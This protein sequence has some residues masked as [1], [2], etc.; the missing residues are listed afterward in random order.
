MNGSDTHP[1]D[2]IVSLARAMDFAAHK[3][4]TQRRK[5]IKAESYVIHLTEVAHLLAEATGGSD[6]V[7]VMAALLHDT[8]E[9]TDTTRAEL[10]ETF[11]KEVES[12]VSDVTDDKNLPREERKRLQVET[13]SHKPARVR[14]LKIADKIA[15]LR[16]I[17]E[18]PPV[19]WSGRRKREYVA[20]AREVV[21]ACGP[22][23]E[24]L[25]MQFEQAARILEQ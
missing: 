4:A 9:D 21:A 25:E 11:G 18:S 6:P 13:A 1:G 12:L 8:I 16:S 15:N 20:W 2:P 10:V 23:N 5:G 24:M 22:T 14:M 19:G 3:H 7:L 17:A